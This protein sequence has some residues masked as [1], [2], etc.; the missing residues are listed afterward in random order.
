MKDLERVVIT[1]G[2]GFIG[3]AVLREFGTGCTVLV[4]DNFHPQV[5]SDAAAALGRLP[6]H[7]DFLKADVTE[8]ATADRVAQFSP[9]VLIHL[10]AETGTGQSLTQSRQHA[11]VNAVGTANLLDGFSRHRTIP[12]RIVLASSRAVYGEGRWQTANGTTF[13]AEPRTQARFATGAW[14]PLGPAG[15]VGESPTA[16]DAS[17]VE[18][19]PSNMYAATKL[20]QEHLLQAWAASFGSEVIVLRLQ[21]VYGTGQSLTN[22]YTGVLTY[23]AQ[24]ALR[25]ESI[26]VFEGGGIIRDFVY[27]EDVARAVVAACHVPLAPV[28]RNVVDIGSGEPVSLLDVARALASLSEAPPP[29]TSSDYRLGD[30]RAA[31]A[32]GE[33]AEQLLGFRPRVSQPEGLAALLQWVTEDAQAKARA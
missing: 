24:Q 2:A 8:P 12:S 23:M 21:N 27:V 1:G 18:P 32:A 3:Q 7:V 4:V 13:Y 16:H 31:F 19:R 26:N 11:L 22:P 17:T 28:L 30:V 33:A 25:G 5:H 9:D 29:H 15:E 14:A 20:A 10:A 6:G